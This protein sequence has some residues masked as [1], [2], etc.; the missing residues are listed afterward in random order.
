MSIVEQIRS[1]LEEKGDYVIRANAET[2]WFAVSPKKL[3]KCRATAKANGRI[4]F[5][6]VVYRTKTNSERD[7]YVIPFSQ[8]TDLFV[9]ES[10]THS[11]ANGSI[12]WNSTLKEGVLHVSHTGKYCDVSRFHQKPLISEL[13]SS[14]SL[15]AEEVLEDEVFTEGS[16]VR[17]SVNR[18]ERDL[19]ARR[20]CIE[21]FGPICSAC[22]FNF[23][24]VY[25]SNME[26]FIH[27][28]HLTPLHQA[29]KDYVVNPHTDLVPVCPNCHA[30]I[31][32]KRPPFTISEVKQ[33][34]QTNGT[35]S[36][37]MAMSNRRR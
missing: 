13:S 19:V 20:R 17:V 31:H 11:K 6:L 36:F 14:Q 18:Y 26:G 16:V 24:A 21:L 34:I 1:A 25:G 7:H 4:D 30:V 3:E 8:V 23:T 12:R 37:A 28:H 10:L 29:G 33:L 35:W 32:S 5:N 27:V 15:L 22:G 9:E 2:G